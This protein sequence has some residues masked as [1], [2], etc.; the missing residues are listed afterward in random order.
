MVKISPDGLRYCKNVLPAGANVLAGYQYLHLQEAKYTMQALEAMPEAVKNWYGYVSLYVDTMRG[1][2]ECPDDEDSYTCTARM[3]GL[4]FAN[5]AIITSKMALDAALAG[6]YSQ[7]F[8]LM[9]HMLETWAQITN[10]RL[11]PAVAKQ[12]MGN[13]GGTP[14]YEPSYGAVIKSL[15]KHATH[16]GEKANIQTGEG[17]IRQL[18]KGAHPSRILVAQIR[19]NEPGITRLGG[20]LNLERLREAMSIG[21]VATALLLHETAHLYPETDEWRSTFQR[22]GEERTAWHGK[23]DADQPSG[24]VPNAPAS[25]VPAGTA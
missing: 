7:A 23:A 18:N 5:G 14:T 6:H 12:W 9:R 22:L 24:S 4:H 20:N 21:T 19:T 2:Y 3:L 8:G 1:D 11:N 17:L 15:R 10:I 13:P 25:T 16:L